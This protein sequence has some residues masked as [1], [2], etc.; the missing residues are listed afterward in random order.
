MIDQKQLI[1]LAHY[2]MPFGKFQGRYLTDIPEEYFIW[3]RQKG[4][5]TG[6]LGTFMQIMLDLKANGEIQFL[7]DIRNL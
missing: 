1:E 4:W 6:K 5:P 2:K 3:Y 7:R